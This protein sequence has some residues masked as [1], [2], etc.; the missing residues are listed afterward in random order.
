MN[1][2]RPYGIEQVTIHLGGLG[3]F[4]AQQKFHIYT[5]GLYIIYL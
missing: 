5:R 1:P 3:K 4:P 2:E